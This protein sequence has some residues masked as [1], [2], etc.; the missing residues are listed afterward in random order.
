[1]TTQTQQQVTPEL[2]KWIVEQA[3]AGHSADSV[4]KAMMASGW[5]E[6]VATDAM[7]STLRGHLEEEAQAKGLPPGVPVPDPDLAESPDVEISICLLEDLAERG[8]FAPICRT[9][10]DAGVPVNWLG[11]GRR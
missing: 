11:E 5:S 3:Q 6:E 7:E 1:M 10:D 9:L 8:P 2:R 4:L